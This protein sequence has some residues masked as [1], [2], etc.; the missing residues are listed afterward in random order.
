MLGVCLPLDLSEPG[1]LEYDFPG[2]GCSKEGVGCSA[3]VVSL[4]ALTFQA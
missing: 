1:T 4:N 2:L 3:R